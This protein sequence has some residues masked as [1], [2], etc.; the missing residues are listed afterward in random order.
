M[1]SSQAKH[2]AHEA[3]KDGGDDDDD[4]GHMHLPKDLTAECRNAA[5][6]G[7]VVVR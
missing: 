1:H 2:R 3:R 7:Q 5:G 6:T 4:D